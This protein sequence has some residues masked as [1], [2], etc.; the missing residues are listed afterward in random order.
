[1]TDAA[2]LA[3]WRRLAD[4][5]TPG[6]WY[7]GNVH[8]QC[9]EIWIHTRA[10]QDDW[11]S[12]DEQGSDDRVVATGLDD[13]SDDAAFIAASREAV[14]VLIVENARLKGVIERYA[15]HDLVCPHDPCSCGFDDAREAI[16]DSKAV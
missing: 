16:R 6:P 1:M 5:A 10:I 7:A 9:G 3:E 8:P 11:E 4:A 2:Q 12:E 15:D 14:P 13:S